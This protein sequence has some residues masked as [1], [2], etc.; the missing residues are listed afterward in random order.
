MATAHM[1]G[2]VGWVSELA[3]WWPEFELRHWERL[4][5]H[6]YRNAEPEHARLN[7][8]LEFTFANPPQTGSISQ[9]S[10]A[11]TTPPS[12]GWCLRMLVEVAE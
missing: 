7:P 8:L 6:D 12:G 5:A 3:T 2:A 10:G 1:H 11:L 4:E 9:S